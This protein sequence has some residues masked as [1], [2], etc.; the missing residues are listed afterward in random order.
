MGAT[1]PRSDG[2]VDATAR[3]DDVPIAVVLDG[4]ADAGLLGGKGAALDRLVGWGFPVPST[5]VV[6]VEAYRRLVA[7]RA[8]RPLVEALHADADLGAEEI[9]AV[10]AAASF[11]AGD[12][13]T[14]LAMARAVADG[15]PLAVRSSATVEDLERSSFAGQYHSV[16]DVDA[17][18]A[19]AVLAAVKS[20]FASLWH[21]A[22]R[23]YRRSF[24]IGDE[25]AAMAAVVMRMVPAV[26]AGV[27]FT[28]D[29]GG[30]TT[31]ARV[32]TVEGLA[33]SLVSGRQTPV[34]AVLPR[35]GVR[36]DADEVEEALGLALQVEERAG[37]AQDVEW[38]W[39][40]ERVWLV[41]ARPITV[42]GS[43]EGDGFD[44][45]QAEI[46]QM[47]LT[48]E[49]IGEMLPGVLP[50]LV[51]T[52]DAHLV[53]EAFRR[54]L[55]DLGMLPPDLAAAR[56]LVRRV[57]GR[58]A[59]D[60]T[61]L[62]SMVGALSGAV[63]VDLEAQYFGS[64][65]A[66]APPPQSPSRRRRRL[67]SAVHDVRVLLARNRYATEAVT[68]VE[69]T[70]GILGARPDLQALDGPGLL[71]YH[72]QLLDL[73]ARGM[74]AELGVATDATATHRR[75]EQMLRRHLDEVRA[76]RLTDRL[77][78]R[79]GLTAPVASGASAAVFA[80]PTW[81]EL[82]RVPPV[83][84]VREPQGEQEEAALVEV[85]AALGESGTWDDDAWL[86]RF[87]L[88][89]MR[90][91]A[92]EAAE[93]LARREQAKA[94][95]LALG[96]E[97]R[98]VHLEIGR[99]LV[100]AGALTDPLEVDLLTREEV[101]GAVL[102]GATVAPDVLR[103]RSRWRTRYEQEGP[104][105]A[106]FSGRP[107]RVRDVALTDRRIEGWAAS[108]G[109]FRGR[110]QVVTSPDEELAPDAVMVAEATDPSWSPLFVR[111]GALVLDRG[112][113]LSHAAILARE[114]G[115][116]AVLNVPGATAL[117]DGRVVT[118]DGDEGIV[119]VHDEEG[120]S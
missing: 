49:G 42:T 85:R 25:S 12:A 113:P 43:D 1:P 103:V 70:R 83:P 96:G 19:E 41:Q 45:P 48:T 60:F 111:A 5:G 44:D 11:G 119:V 87:R 86:S 114:L 30:D 56:V 91:L 109:R 35:S 66:V 93:R 117:L 110:V 61:R 3:V 13:S 116:P 69:A 67:R 80:G 29:P 21:P 16:L 101:R 7:D 31:M 92:A 9:D 15:A 81:A 23:A 53:E 73:A 102:A 20:V 40:G 55:D 65:R 99:R 112:G 22:P 104:L 34:A 38:A 78:T 64:A 28:I 108:G 89:A 97:V 115:L 47:D 88:R 79:S 17:G 36:D 71:A 100:D 4:H 118:V 98:R 94:A 77:V 26:R 2:V 18:D 95:L 50:P 75:L 14:I 37:R 51:W 8:L 24:G 58:A 10:F 68:L 82:G 52:I 107:T 63:A 54:L 105:P 120:A 6:T 106:R 46:E 39:D 33:E 32:E 57:R 76:A 72:L 84:P 74:T 27:V 59:M 90:R 62:Q